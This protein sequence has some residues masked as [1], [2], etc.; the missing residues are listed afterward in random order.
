[1]CLENKYNHLLHNYN[2]KASILRQYNLDN[3]WYAASSMAA[4]HTNKHCASAGGDTAQVDYAYRNQKDITR[5][6]AC[7]FPFV[8]H[9]EFENMF[10]KNFLS[11]TDGKI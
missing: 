8:F 9:I 1:M 10:P 5:M 2:T 7:I 4:T 11:E 3:N 6:L